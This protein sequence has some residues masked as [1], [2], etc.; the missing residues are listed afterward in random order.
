MDIPNKKKE[1]SLECP[2]CL[3]ILSQPRIL[4]SCEHTLFSECILMSKKK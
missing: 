4:T 2:V 3:E 1:R